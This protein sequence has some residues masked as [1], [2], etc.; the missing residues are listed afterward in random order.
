[1]VDVGRV[2]SDH[3][4]LEVSNRPTWPQQFGLREDVG[5]KTQACT[6]KNDSNPVNLISQSAE[7]KGLARLID[8][9]LEVQH[10]RKNGRDTG[11]EVV[12]KAP[13]EAAVLE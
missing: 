6:G 12:S 8:R 7:C 9:Q 10:E 13:T 3:T 1:M 2:I 4:V 11:A 5:D